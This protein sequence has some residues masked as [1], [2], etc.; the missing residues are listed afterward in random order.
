MFLT[1][2]KELKTRLVLQ[3]SPS[4][5]SIPSTNMPPHCGRIQYRRRYRSCPNIIDRKEWEDSNSFFLYWFCCCGKNILNSIDIYSNST[6]NGFLQNVN[7]H[8]IVYKITKKKAQ[9]TFTSFSICFSNSSTVAV[10]SP[11]SYGQD[12]QCV[13]FLGF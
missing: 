4:P 6:F 9:I 7:A 12:K 10:W 1:S 5:L 13:H 8:N 2:D 11:S 3:D